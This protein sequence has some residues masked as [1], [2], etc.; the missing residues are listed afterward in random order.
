MIFKT[1]AECETAFK[2]LLKDGAHRSMDSHWGVAFKGMELKAEKVYGEL[3]PQ[4]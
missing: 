2:G 3:L 4:F 1:R